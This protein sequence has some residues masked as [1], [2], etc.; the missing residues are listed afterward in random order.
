MTAEVM[1]R[2]ALNRALLAR[3]MLLRRREMPA[4]EAIEHLVGMQAQ[5]PKDPYLGLWTRLA[6]FRPDE[7]AGLILARR[8]V[9]GP[10]M[11]TTVHLVSA[12]DCLTLRPLVQPVLERVFHGQFGRALV[13]ADLGEV[14]AAGRALLE[15]RPRTRAELRPLL[16]E[17]WPGHDAGALAQAVGY[18]V[19]VVQVPLRGVWGMSGQ[20]ILALTESWLERHLEPAPSPDEMVVRY[21][22]AYGPASVKDAQTWC[23]LTRLREVTE[24][25]RPRLRVFLD[26]NG[27][28][29][30]DLPDAPRPDP[31]TPAPARFLP[32]YDNVLLSHADRSRVHTGGY[33]PPPHAGKGGF[34]GNVLV[35]G[36]FRATFTITRQRDGASLLITPFERLPRED[37]TALSEEGEQLLRFVTGPEGAEAFEVRFAENR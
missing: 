2:H 12:R 6:D 23:G 20:A 29:L 1:G 35:D 5:A 19:P 3:Q 25:L 37:A 14:V 27:Q 28:E 10:L 9:R 18:L 17:R 22:A 16:A 30:F 36:F 24:R 33:R 4:I 34:I 13:G 32:E 15:E 11:R 31:D 26:E 21:L 8:A 7:L